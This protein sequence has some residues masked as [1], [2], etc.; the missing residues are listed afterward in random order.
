MSNPYF[1]TKKIQNKIG[2]FSKTIS[3]STELL[4]IVALIFLWIGLA[5][6]SPYFLS[7][8]NLRNI[9][10]EG[11]LLALI[12]FGMTL[13]LLV[14]GIDLS[15][16]SVPALAGVIAASFIVD[17]QILVGVILGLLVGIGS[18]LI[19]G[20]LIGYVKIP[21][22]IATYGMFFI[23]KGLALSYTGG[24][25]I[26]S[27][28]MKFRWISTG[29]I[30]GLP[31]PI[32]ITII[33]ASILTFLSRRTVIGKNI[34]AVGTN[35]IAAKY[36][37]INVSF[38]LLLAYLTSGFLSGIAALISIAR[39]D[40]AEPILG[41][42]FTLDAISAVVLG[43]TSF[44]GGKGGFIGTVIG[45]FIISTIRNGLNLLRVQTEWQIILVGVIVLLAVALDLTT[46][47]SSESL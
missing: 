9:L 37:G 47:S 12:S 2:E 13:A 7:W 1:S 23:A 3:S 28:D 4:R 17:G 18:G 8:M 35:R 15:L 31:A 38:T 27:F 45:A 41:A 40:A 43:G 11:S 44:A 20:T 39:L 22:V 5:F 16:G 42:D 6:V 33:I 34:Y 19:I 30:F 14:Q 32:V 36:S 26:Y 21:P 24:L 29:K 10:L 25:A 46:K